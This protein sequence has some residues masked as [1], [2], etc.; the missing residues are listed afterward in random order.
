LSDELVYQRTEYEVMRVAGHASF[1]TTHRFYLAIHDSLL[2]R[3]RQASS[4]A[5]E[6]ISVA[7]LLQVSSGTQSED[8]SPNVTP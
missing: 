4:K 5:M 7:G 6:V 1:E 3:T 2:E 8:Q